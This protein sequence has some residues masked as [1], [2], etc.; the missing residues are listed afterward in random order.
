MNALEKRSNDNQPLTPERRLMNEALARIGAMGSRST[1]RG[2]RLVFILDLTGSRKPSLR[3]ARIATAAMFDAIKRIGSIAVKLIFYRGN[4]DCQSSQWESDPAVVSRAMERLSCE[5]GETQIGRSLRYVLEQEKEPVSGIVF[6]GEHCEEDPEQ[7]A[8]LAR[9]LGEKRI[10]IF[11][12]HECQDNNQRAVNAKPVF[13]R[14]ADASN[15]IY[16]EFEP[17]SGLVLRE[18]LS[19]VAA[20][21]TARIEGVKEM[22]QAAT[23]QA[24]Q[25]QRRL[26]LL[27]AGPAAKDLE[28]T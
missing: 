3:Q 8:Q 7:L 28:V 5:A 25:L 24:Q 18:L 10:P 9:A 19:S 26:L 12:F 17:E 1:Q 2:G 22:G 23:P 13:K 14:I 20:F 16:A 27:A 15:G 11:V 4:D 21:S 6:I